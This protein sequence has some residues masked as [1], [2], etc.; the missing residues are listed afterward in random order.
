MN[1]P[2][3][4][5]ELKALIRVLETGQE[6]GTFEDATISVCEDHI[7][8]FWDKGDGIRLDVA[9]LAKSSASVDMEADV[10]QFG[11]SLV[12]ELCPITESEGGVQ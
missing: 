12:V 7:A 1:T 3:Y 9:A 4:H 8:F 5:K 2:N 11:E 10:V 6:E